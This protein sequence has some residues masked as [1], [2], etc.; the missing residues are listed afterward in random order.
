MSKELVLN[1]HSQ[2]YVRIGGASYRKAVKAGHIIPRSAVEQPAVEQPDHR[3][4]QSK[5]PLTGYALRLGR[6]GN[7]HSRV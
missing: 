1:P 7:P 4:N 2:R 3:L 5:P 6:G